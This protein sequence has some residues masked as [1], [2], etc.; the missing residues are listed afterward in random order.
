MEAL[1]IL[2]TIGIIVALFGYMDDFSTDN[3]TFYFGI[4]V[5]VL[6]TIGIA[7]YQKQERDKKSTNWP[8]EISQLSNNPSKPD[9]LLGYQIDGKYY[10]M[11]INKHK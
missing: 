3:I 6:S 1:Y 10:I 11:Y 8:E 9:T 7:V 4:L 2:L 5:A